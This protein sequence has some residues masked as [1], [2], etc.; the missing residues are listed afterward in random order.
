MHGKMEAVRTQQR[1][2]SQVAQ[3]ERLESRPVHDHANN[4]ADWGRLVGSGNHWK[5]WFFLK[6]RTM[7]RE[8]RQSFSDLSCFRLAWELVKKYIYLGPRPD[9]LNPNL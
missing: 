1:V 8:M 7:V 9:L 4:H 3:E 6:G 2:Y 5:F